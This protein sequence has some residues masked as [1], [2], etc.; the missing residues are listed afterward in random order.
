MQNESMHPKY[1]SLHEPSTK[2]SVDAAAA[3]LTVPVL[4]TLFVAAARALFAPLAGA[5]AVDAVPPPRVRP[6]P[7]DGTAVPAV[8]KDDFSR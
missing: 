1:F 7:A 4:T 6:P 8:G 3:I 5:D 2:P